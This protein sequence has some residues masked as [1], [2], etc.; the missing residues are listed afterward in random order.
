MAELRANDFDN[1]IRRRASALLGLIEEATGK[2]VS[3][4]D[5]EETAKAFGGVLT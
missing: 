2:A 5:S 4:R 1:F 3:G